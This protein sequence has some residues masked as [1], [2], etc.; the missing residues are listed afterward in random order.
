MVRVLGLA[1]G[2][3][4]WVGVTGSRAGA[5]D[6]PPAPAPAA[7]PELKIGLARPMFRDVPPAMVNA[8]AKP[9]QT[10]I[11][12]KAGVKG[13]VEVVDDYT[14]LVDRMRAGKLDICVLHGFEYAWVKD[15]PGLAAMCVTLPN[16]GKVQVCLVV[17]AD[18]K[19]KEAKDL[20]GE[21]VLVPRGT[22]GY[23]HMFLDH[24]R[25]KCPAG[26]CS[27]AKAGDLTATEA[28]GKVAIGEARAALVDLAA[29]QSLQRELPGCFKQLK[30]LEQSAELPSA[31]V[32]YRK[33]ALDAATV[34]RI[35]KGLIDCVKTPIGKT[36]A[37]FWQLRGFDEVTPAYNKLVDEMLKA[38]PAPQR[39]TPAPTESPK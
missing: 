9:F 11:Q 8:A 38:Y 3:A 12:D 29:L 35:R 24:L 27:P 32:V 39:P 16:A 25:E 23:C 36:F 6:P 10:M 7:A 28:M 33:E 31:V 37:L 17:N 34:G 4:V 14:I 2:L 18:S 30:V 13:S 22:K 15:T 26:C 20:E 21:C 5:A 1:A 19:A